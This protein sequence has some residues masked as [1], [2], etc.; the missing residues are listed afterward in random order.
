MKSLIQ[1][2]EDAY[3]SDDPFKTL[4]E[5]SVTHYSLQNMIPNAHLIHFAEDSKDIK[6]EIETHLETFKHV[7]NETLSYRYGYFGTLF[8][9]FFG[10][11][12]IFTQGLPN[13]WI[14]I[15]NEELQFMSQ[16]EMKRET[17]KVLL[18]NNKN[19]IL[20]KTSINLIT[21]QCMAA[22][23]GVFIEVEADS[24]SVVNNP[25]DEFCFVLSYDMRFTGVFRGIQRLHSI[26]H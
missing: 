19:N 12:G 22:S 20:C 13:V 10:K 25:F 15:K 24:M 5:K 6:K 2:L 17:I 18:K 26:S 21:K 4:S 7:S 23:Q 1:N 3:R 16:R 9:H 14:N 11:L 8:C